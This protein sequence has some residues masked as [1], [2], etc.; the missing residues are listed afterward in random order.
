MAFSYGKKDCAKTGEDVSQDCR[1]TSSSKNRSIILLSLMII[2]WIGILFTEST[3]PPAEF[4]RMIPQLDKVAH[5]GAF[6]ILGLLV[7]SLSLKLRL[8]SSIPLFTL[9]LLVV[10]LCGVLEEC[11]QMLVPGR[12]ASIPDLLADTG[13]GI[14]AILLANRV[15]C[16]MKIGQL[17]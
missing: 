2:G 5:F 9:S 16:K 14:F 17:R 1:R 3:R 6:F 12:T 4:L 10:T 7:C 8:K 11:L 15:S 13:G